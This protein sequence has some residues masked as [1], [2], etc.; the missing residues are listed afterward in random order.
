MK[1]IQAVFVRQPTQVVRSLIVLILLAVVPVAW[2]QKRPSILTPLESPAAQAGAL[3]GKVTETMNAAGYT[4]VQL[5]TGAKKV[6]VAAPR[7]AVKVGDTVATKDSMPMEK[8]HSKTLNRDFDVVYFTGNVTVNGK[9]TAPEAAELPKGHPPLSGGESKSGPD[10]SKIKKAEGGKT[11][12][13]L[14]AE[15]KQLK[16]KEIKVRGKVVKYNAEIMGKNWLHVQDGTGAPG[17]NDLT[18]TTA[19]KAKVGD[20]VLITGKIST[21]RDFGGGYRYGLIIEDARVV[22]E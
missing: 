14:Y 21:D 5:N 1:A 2:A 12:S 6:W 22:V 8:Y 18:V 17:S 10:F 15:Q 19:G 7:F 13:E 20:T 16:G 11:I 3:T 9:S 4:Y